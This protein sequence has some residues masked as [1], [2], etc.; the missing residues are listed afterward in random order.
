MQAV[1]LCG[2][3]GMRMSNAPDLTP[4][5]LVKVGGMPLL[6]HIIKLF[7][8]YAIQDFI[9]CLGDKSEAIKE[10]FFNLDWKAHDFKLTE[11]GVQYYH[12]PENWNIIFADTGKDTQ[13]G[14]R[15][16][17][18]E[19]YLTGDDFLLT[20]SDGLANISLP[21]LLTQHKKMKRLATVTGVKR[22]SAY[23]IMEENHG[24][25]ASFREKPQLDGWVNGGF[26]VLKK[27]VLKYLQ[28]D[29]C[30]WEEQ[31]LRQLAAEG[32]LALYRHQGFWQSLDSPKE[33]Q[34]VNEMWARDD[35]PWVVW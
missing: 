24:L 34:I 20:Y 3:K 32:Q 8:T 12:P 1:I 2:G 26:F 4:K 7:Q 9:L 28:G 19:K 29:Q 14:G 16:K 31:P 27:Q 25:V 10:Y 33:V 17:R 23:G 30:I 15:I 21:K 13:T 35:R 22:P 11:K 18:I 5:P 6:M